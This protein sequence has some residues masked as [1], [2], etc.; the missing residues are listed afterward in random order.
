MAAV[1]GGKADAFASDKLLLVGAQ[2][3]NPQAL[4][5]LPDDLSIEPYPIYC[6][7]AIGLCG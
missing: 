1:E 3:K 6:R 5:M 7:A 4:I 2:F